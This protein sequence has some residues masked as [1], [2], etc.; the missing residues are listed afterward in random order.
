MMTFFNRI[1]T[2]DETQI[3]QL[4]PENEILSKEW[5]PKGTP[6]PVKLEAERS[7]K[8]VMATIL[9]NFEG[10]VLIDFLEGK[11]TVASSFC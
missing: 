3:D 1:I 11:K 5:H 9:R 10:G 4:D 7:V 2:G 6:G 8:K